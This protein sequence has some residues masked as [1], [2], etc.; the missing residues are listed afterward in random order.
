MLANSLAE[1]RELIVWF[2]RTNRLK[3]P[4]AAQVLEFI[5]G[6]KTLLSRVQFT[7]NL[8]DKK[9]A[10]LISAVYT[11]TF[12]FDFRRNNVSYG[13]V[14]EVIY[15]LK[16]NP[17]TKLYMWLSYASP[18][19]CLLCTQTN[20]RRVATKRNPA[21]I[22]HRMLVDAVRTVNKKEARRK[23]LLLKIDECLDEKN[24]LEFKKLTEELHR[25][26]SE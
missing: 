8:S 18:P 4:E 5:K 17:P 23:A 20:R 10:V 1:K 16:Q 11:N 13:S 25:L 26:S 15:Q 14:D 21:A 7:H 24:S 12:P 19:N 3:K 22:A 2:L 6:D 9:D